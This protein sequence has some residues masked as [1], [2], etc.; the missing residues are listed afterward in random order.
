MIK[1]LAGELWPA[2][3][4]NM[5]SF[6]Y[7]LIKCTTFMRIESKQDFNIEPVYKGDAHK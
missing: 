7:N 5:R 1:E 6:R 2:I 4:S 3:H